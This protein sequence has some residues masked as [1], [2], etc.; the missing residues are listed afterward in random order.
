MPGEKRNIRESILFITHSS[1]KQL[2][3]TQ[4]E[5]L[6]AVHSQQYRSWVGIDPFP[7]S[8]ADRAGGQATLQALVETFRAEKPSSPESVDEVRGKAFN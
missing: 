8:L 7:Q 6:F 5:S 3:A 4:T 1:R 2:I